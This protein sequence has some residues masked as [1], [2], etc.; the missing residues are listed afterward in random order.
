MSPFEVREILAKGSGKEFDPVVV[1]AFL[2]M[3]Q[4]GAMEVPDLVV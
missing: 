1:E 3:F 2:E 4:Q